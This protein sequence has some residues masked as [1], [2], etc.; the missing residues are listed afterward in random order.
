MQP[1]EGEKTYRS[2][3]IIASTVG[4]VVPL[5]CNL[6]TTV[7]ADGLG[8]LDT[9]GVALDVL[10]SDVQNGVVVRRRVDVSTRLVSYTLILSVDE[11]VPFREVSVCPTRSLYLD[12]LTRRWCGQQRAGH[13]QQEQEQ[14]RRRSSL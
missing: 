10:G 14:E 9:S 1:C 13:R 3:D 2:N 11:N 4:V 7:D 6:I 8:G 12:L 5:E